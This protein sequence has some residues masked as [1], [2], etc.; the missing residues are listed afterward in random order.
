MISVYQPLAEFD[1][2]VAQVY[3]TPTACMASNKCLLNNLCL[4]TSYEPVD[5]FSLG[6]T[7][8]KPSK[9]VTKILVT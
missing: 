7:L 8:R 3:F 5:T 6:S 1:I 9:H 4:V 2:W